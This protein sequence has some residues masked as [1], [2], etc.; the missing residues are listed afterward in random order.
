MPILGWA[1]ASECKKVK[2]LLKQ[3]RSR[4][5][6][7]KIQRS[8]IS[9][10]LRKDLEKLD[11]EELNNRIKQEQ[12]IRDDSAAYDLLE[13]F[14]KIILRHFFYIRTHKKC[15]QRTLAEAVSS[16]V[17]ASSRLRC[18]VIPELEKIRDFFKE[19]YGED[20]V[21]TAVNL[22]PGNLVNPTFKK[23]ILALFPDS[24]VQTDIMKKDDEDGKN[25]LQLVTFQPLK[26]VH[27]KLP[28]W[29]DIVAEFSALKK[30]KYEQYPKL[31]ENYDIA[32]KMN[33]FNAPENESTA[34]NYQFQLEDHAY[35][36]NVDDGA[37]L[38]YPWLS[39]GSINFAIQQECY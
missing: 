34:D 10:Q 3:A 25:Q 24:V 16:L 11:L 33:D 28:D 6:C 15:G 21:E 1:K 18:G 32:D 7:M 14:C 26:H 30:P 37:I 2:K 4:L 8:V 38:E 31:S 9:L 27:P 20:F 5:D 19:R 36:D 22:L 29:D 39:I 13:H 17:F 35:H 12:H 23:N